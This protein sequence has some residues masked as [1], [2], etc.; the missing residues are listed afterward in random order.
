MGSTYRLQT[1]LSTSLLAQDKRVQFV[2]V[3]CYGALQYPQNEEVLWHERPSMA[4]VSRLT[5]IG[6]ST[7]YES[8]QQ[9]R[10]PELGSA[11]L[12]GVDRLLFETKAWT[13]EPFVEAWNSQ[14]HLL[15]RDARAEVESMLIVLACWVRAVPGVARFAK[16]QLP[17]SARTFL[18]DMR[19]SPEEQ[20]AR[21]GLGTSVMK[22][23][24]ERDHLDPLE[25]IAGLAEEIS[26]ILPERDDEESVLSAIGRL[27]SWLED[28]VLQAL[29]E[30]ATRQWENRYVQKD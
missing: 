6:T 20:W 19:L 13:F 27:S 17:A 2:R 14:R 18:I 5:G 23:S 30:R 29:A 11:H 28:S 10:Y 21:H 25:V 16:D 22:T 12:G 7:L 3:R 8:F 15:Q 9:G 26:A 4:W 1:P 24:V